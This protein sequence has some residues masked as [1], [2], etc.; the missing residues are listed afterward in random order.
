MN[1]QSG[2]CYRVLDTFYPS[3]SPETVY[4]ALYAA[5]VAASARNIATGY[6]L[7]YRAIACAEARGYG[8]AAL[9]AGA[10]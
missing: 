3:K 1:T 7:R 5:T 8:I 9:A 6:P 4:L 2:S 10:L